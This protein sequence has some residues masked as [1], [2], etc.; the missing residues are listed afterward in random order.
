[1][2]VGLVLVEVVVLDDKGKPIAGLKK[3]DFRIFQDDREQQISTFDAVSEEADKTSLP[4]SLRD[5]DE[6]TQRGKVVLLLFDQSTISSADSKLTLDAAEKY[7]RQHMHPY[8]LVGVAVYVQ[9]IRITCPLTHDAAKVIEAIHRASEAFA[10]KLGRAVRDTTGAKELRSQVVDVFRNLKGL[11]SA[12]EPVRGRK[13]VLLF[14]ED[15]SVPT[16]TLIEFNSLVSEARKS[17]VSFFTLDARGR[18][19]SATNSASLVDTNIGARPSTL[20]QGVNL[21][22]FQDQTS[23]TILRSLANQT[24]GYPIYNT[25]NLGEAL[26]RV[27]LELGHY[28]VLGSQSGSARSDGKPRKIEVKLSLKDARLKY[29]DTYTDSHPTD[30]LA[31]SKSESSLRAALSSSTLATQLPVFFRPVYFYETPQVA[32]IPVFVKLGRGSIALKKKAGQWTGSAS[33]MGVALEE[34]GTTASRFSGEINVAIGDAQAEAFHNQ[35]LVYKNSLRLRPGKYRVKL[36][37]MDEKGKTGTAEQNLSIPAFDQ[38]AMTASSLIISQEMVPL[39]GLIRELKPQMLSQR[40]PLQFKGFQVYAPVEAEIDRQQPMVVFYR[41]YVA[42]GGNAEKSFKAKVQAIDE[43]GES[44]PFAPVDLSSSALPVSQTET[45]IGFMLSCHDL[46]AGKYH[47]M[48]ETVEAGSG[49]SVTSEADFQLRGSER[50]PVNGRLLQANPAQ[51]ESASVPPVRVVAGQWMPPD[52]DHSAHPMRSD[53]TCSL[54]D[55]LAGAGKRIQ[56]LIH[57]IDRFTATEVLEHQDTDRQGNLQAPEIRKFDYMVSI[58]EVRGGLMSVEELRNR[59]VTPLHFPSHLATLGTPSI[60]LI[61]HPRYIQDFDMDCE[62]LGDWEGQPTW[63]VRFEQR[64][65]RPNNLR[66]YSVDGN[67]YDVRLRGRAWIRADTYQVVRVET[68][69]ADPIPKIQLRLEHMQIEYHPVD[70]PERGVVLWLPESAELY[71]D[72]RGHHIRRRHYFT[73]FKLFSV[74]TKQ[75]I[76]N[77]KG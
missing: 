49:Q 4:S 46:K 62:G 30:P 40:D 6:R 19:E 47:L 67:R 75:E 35:D 14:T 42:P 70:F 60:V 32:Q 50:E 29:R 41:V 16:D 64:K 26:D 53:T 44:H 9:S 28:Y 38:G 72:F 39:P 48:V 77:P 57:N 22:Q 23:A 5:I 51:A 34:D 7:V 2:N 73:D 76:A 36:V 21:A 3:E 37:V 54:A 17:D 74:E 27:D 55:V 68:D 33:V 43:K 10:G 25:D 52:I 69:L 63:L 65:D 18:S 24:N 12:L 61:F 66:S 31:G 71:M 13:T 56:E 45:A 1:V 11:C 15:M 58:R 8:D 59:D 20:S